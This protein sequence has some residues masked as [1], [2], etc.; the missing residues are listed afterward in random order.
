M[1][2]KLDQREPKYHRG[3]TFSDGTQYFTSHI[4][5]DSLQ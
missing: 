2:H 4:S 3:Q 1:A 5:D